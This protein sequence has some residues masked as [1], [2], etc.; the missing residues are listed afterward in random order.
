MDGALVIMIVAL[1]VAVLG[2]TLVVVKWGLA[3]EEKRLA[4][5]ANGGADVQRMEHVLAATQAEVTNLRER[6][7]VLEKLATDDD[8]KL[9]SDIE[10]LRSSDAMRG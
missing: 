8:R 5:K 9:A 2:F 1:V 7:Q 4:L 3:H 6:V 10:R